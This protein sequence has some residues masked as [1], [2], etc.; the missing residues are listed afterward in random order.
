LSQYNL[1]DSGAHRERESPA[2][3]TSRARK[4]KNVER[5]SPGKITRVSRCFP[6]AFR[7]VSVRRVNIYQRDVYKKIIAFVF[8]LCSHGHLSFAAEGCGFAF[9][10]KIRTDTL[11]SWHEISFPSHK[12]RRWQWRRRWWWRPAAAHGRPKTRDSS[13]HTAPT[14]G[15]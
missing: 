4:I 9:W 10:L 15:Q 14:R 12:T 2:R 11:T 7:G 3:E 1:L 13:R 8:K 6:A 5:R